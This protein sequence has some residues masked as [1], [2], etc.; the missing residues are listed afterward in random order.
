MSYFIFIK[1]IKAGEE[2]IVYG[3]GNQERD[4]TYIDDIAKGTIATLKL[5]G[6][7]IINLGNNHPVKLNYMINL[8]E[9]RK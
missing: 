4:F 1:K 9:F 3:N 5:K 6:F 8:I 2:I 7:Q